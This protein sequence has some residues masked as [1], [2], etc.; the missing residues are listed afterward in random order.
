MKILVCCGS[1]LGS[2]FMMEINIKK[3]LK[4]L[5]V[6]N[7]DVDHSDLGSAKGTKADVYVGT[8]DIA[9]QLTSLGGEVISLNSMIDLNELKSKLVETLTKMAI[10]K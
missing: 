4:E 6:T 10:I 2:S 5:N 3:V 8:R 9:S 7:V 1:G